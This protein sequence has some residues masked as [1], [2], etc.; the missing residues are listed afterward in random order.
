MSKIKDG[1]KLELQTSKTM[2]LFRST[3]KLIDKIKNGEKV[4][5]LEVVEIVLDQCN[6]I[7]NNHIQKSEVSYTCPPT[8]SYP[9]L[10]NV[11]TS[12]LLLKLTTLSLMKLS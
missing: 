1:H 12:N 4:P 2:K 6:L 8:K 3:N 10:L 7:D 11:E 5:R 9:Y